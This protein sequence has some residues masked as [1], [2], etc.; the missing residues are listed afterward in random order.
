MSKELTLKSIEE[1]LNV[2]NKYYD[3][4][5]L[6]DMVNIIR[7]YT[8]EKITPIIFTCDKK[9]KDEDKPKRNFVEWVKN[10]TDVLERLSEPIPP[11][12]LSN[13]KRDSE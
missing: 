6:D 9:E 1:I 3:K 2:I 4:L 13:V 12:F 8:G 5:S 7:A 11:P 10:N